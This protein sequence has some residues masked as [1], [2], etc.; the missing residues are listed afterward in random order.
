[1]APID[2]TDVWNGNWETTMLWP[3]LASSSISAHADRSP[4]RAVALGD[5]RPAQDHGAGR[6]VGT[7]DEL[8]EVVDRRVGIVDQ[9]QRRV[10]DLGE[11]VRRNVGGHADRNAAATVDQQV[12]ESGGHDERLAVAAVI[13]IAEVDGVLVDL[14]EQLHCER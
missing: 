13:G 2:S 4:T 10:D 7:G 1:L 6:E 11:V 14:A 8:H 12:R 3:P 9:V 5:P